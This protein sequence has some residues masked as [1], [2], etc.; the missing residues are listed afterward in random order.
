MLGQSSRCLALRG[1]ARPGVLKAGGV[2]VW[3]SRGR[4][5][6]AR[7]ASVKAMISPEGERL[8][9]ERVG[10]KVVGRERNREQRDREGKVR[11]RPLSHPERLFGEGALPPLG[12]NKLRHTN[13]SSDTGVPKGGGNKDK[14]V[15]SKI[16]SKIEEE[17]ED[18]DK[19]KLSVPR[20]TKVTGWDKDN[21]DVKRLGKML[22]S[23][24]AREGE[25]V[26][27]LEGVRLIRD[28]VSR[29]LVPST[30]VFSRV[31]LLWQ[32]GLPS[33]PPPDCQLYHIPYTN[34]KLWS[35]LPT[36]PGIMAALPLPLTVSPSSPLPLT[37]VCDNI[38][39]PDNLGAIL[40]VAAA[41]GA[42]RA[43]CVGCCDV[44]NSKV[45]R[46]GS[47]A[48][49]HM[50]MVQ[51]VGWGEVRGLLEDPWSQVVIADLP[52]E[53]GEGEEEVVE[54]KVGEVERRVAALEERLEEEGEG[55]ERGFQM[56]EAMEEYRSLPVRSEEYTQFTLRPGFRE[57]VVV[58]G[59][60]TE[61]GALIISLSRQLRC[62]RIHR[63]CL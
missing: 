63:I 14:K 58:I 3:Q 21:K 11:E 55:G 35:D 16:E 29:G 46:A 44:W 61:V 36:S 1:V 37:V 34:I 42:R 43:V 31:K 52:R 26:A 9:E 32:L 51:G 49:F 47:G 4:A 62:N 13:T 15:E 2:E 40:R 24:R 27:V 5:F 33:T 23:R 60:E 18:E 41:A 53:E 54:L 6:R 10:S 39:G 19:D 20:Y 25:Q 8:V 50:P 22:S 45:L 59:G 17:F 56:E 30:I 7:G 48:H 28:A 12:V 57:V 38:R